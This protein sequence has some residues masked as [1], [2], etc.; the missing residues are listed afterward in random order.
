MNCKPGDLALIVRAQANPAW[1]GRI[2][3]VVRAF[4]PETWVTDPM[5]PGFDC[6]FDRALRPI[7][8]NDGI[9]ETMTW[10]P[11]RKGIAA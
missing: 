7:R 3:I 9:D 4:D 8:D 10:A 5:P 11:K 2:V 1:L 6:V